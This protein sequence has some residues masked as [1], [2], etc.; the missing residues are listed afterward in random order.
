MRW[1]VLWPREPAAAAVTGT[2]SGDHPAGGPRDMRGTRIPDVGELGH[3]FGAILRRCRGPRSRMA[4]RKAVTPASSSSSASTAVTIRAWIT[5]RSLLGCSGS[6]GPARWRRPGQPPPGVLRAAEIAQSSISSQ[7]A[8]S[9]CSSQPAPGSAMS[10]LVHVPAGRAGAV[11]TLA[12]TAMPGVR[13]TGERSGAVV[14]PQCVGGSPGPTD[15][16]TP[17]ASWA[18]NQSARG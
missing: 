6:A 16:E 12:R 3:G 2:G 9:S 7:I 10:Q 11:L 5:L 8:C 18:L 1:P 14:I 15:S 13:S 4:G 17:G